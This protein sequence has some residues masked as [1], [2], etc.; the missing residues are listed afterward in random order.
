MVQRILGWPSWIG[1]IADDLET[2]RRFYRD[3]L[4]FKELKSGDRFVWFDLGGNLLEV[5]AKSER[6]EYKQRGFQVAFAVENI[7]AAR[8]ELLSRGVEPLAEIRGGPEHL[9]YWCRF[10][11]VEGNLFGIHQAVRPGKSEKEH[12]RG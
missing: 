1:V 4:G 7:H 9:G 11:D 8:V 5:I 12:S 10:R 3:V 6:P 2:Q